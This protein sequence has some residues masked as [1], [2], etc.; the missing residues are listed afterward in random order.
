VAASAAPGRGRALEVLLIADDLDG[1]RSEQYGYV[2]R[3]V[4]DD[5]LDD[6]VN[7]IAPRLACSDHDMIARTKSC[8]GG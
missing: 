2:N 6:E 3:A 8:V 4:G 5:R 1:P 7:R